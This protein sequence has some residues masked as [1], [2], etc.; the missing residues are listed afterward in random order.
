M[1]FSNA[2]YEC[3]LL[4]F[5]AANLLLFIDLLFVERS[6]PI[7]AA[8]AKR[9]E[10][11]EAK[12]EWLDR[13]KNKYRLVVLNDD[14][15]E[16]KVSFRL[17]RLNV[18][19]AT[20][21]S[22]I[23]LIGFTIILIAFTPLREYI[24]GYS[25]TALR[26]QALE[27]AVMVDSLRQV[28]ANQE[29]YVDIING[30]VSGNLPEYDTSQVVDASEIDS[31]ERPPSRE[32]TALR[33]LV[34]QEERYNLFEEEQNAKGGLAN[35]TF[36]PPIKGLVSGQFNA[37]TDHYGVDIVA[38][39]NEPIL[40]VLEGTVLIATWSSE[41]GYVLVLQHDQGLISVYKHNSV[42]LKS[43]GELVQAG[44]AIAI[45]GNSGHLS[46]GPHLHFELWVSG[47]SV[48]PESYIV[49]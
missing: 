13:L 31:I 8:M 41:E 39:E 38:A 48:D 40:A 14:T 42:L 23:T 16:E 45:I 4:N 19:V 15:F 3:L 12:Q 20:G 34:E 1:L 11:K 7:F 28:I 25:S 10:K 22:V 49:F 2:N 46:T 6:I 5:G 21:L 47:I 36:F 35:L 37:S 43:Q 32:D 33:V 29:R 24:P 18:F 44:E 30:V 9:T 17:S 26:R 27:N